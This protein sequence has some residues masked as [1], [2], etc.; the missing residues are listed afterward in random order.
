M[1]S[2]RPQVLQGPTA[3]TRPPRPGRVTDEGPIAAICCQAQV[4]AC[5]AAGCSG[6]ISSTASAAFSSSAIWPFS[7]AAYRVSMRGRAAFCFVSTSRRAAARAAGGLCLAAPP[8]ASRS[9]R[10]S[11]S[12]ARPNSPRR[13]SSWA[14]CHASAISRV[15]RNDGP[16]IRAAPAHRSA[17]RPGPVHQR[18]GRRE[19]RRRPGR[20]VSAGPMPGRR[21][22]AQ[23]LRQG[24]ILDGPGQV[25][26]LA[27]PTGPRDQVECEPSTK[28]HG[29]VMIG[30]IRLD[31]P[32]PAPR[33][34][35][36]PG[37][38]PRP[39]ARQFANV[40]AWLTC[41][42]IGPWG[43]P[44]RHVSSRSERLTS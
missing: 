4:R 15:R 41:R 18:R 17:R 30:H 42:P 22:H 16:L 10:S 12:W 29:M 27:A 23:F 19:P 14:D 39:A 38:P 9:A 31:S 35:D 34:S 43:F 5:R 3:G 20:P 11:W 6:T 2:D 28:L 8:V 21:E 26:N 33:R 40:P 7:R 24:E 25:V 13:A 1:D 32:A 44:L 36:P 37:P